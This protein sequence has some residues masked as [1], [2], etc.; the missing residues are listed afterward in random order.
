MKV[1][2]NSTTH[3][4]ANTNYFEFGLQSPQNATIP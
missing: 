2:L 4:A 3:A 1:P